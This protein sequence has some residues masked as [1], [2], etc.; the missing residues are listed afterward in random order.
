MAALGFAI[1]LAAG[2]S[3]SASPAMASGTT[4]MDGSGI[5]GAECTYINGTGSYVDYCRAFSTMGVT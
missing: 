1:V 2:L 4:C 5:I 3:L